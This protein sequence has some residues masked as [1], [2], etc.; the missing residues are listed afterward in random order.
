MTGMAADTLI[1]W[2]LGSEVWCWSR[3]ETKAAINEL[4]RQDRLN[5]STTDP[6]GRIYIE[7]PELEA[8]G[9]R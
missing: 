6:P 3:P 4:A 2:L 8:V 1:D 7:V 5:L 9:K